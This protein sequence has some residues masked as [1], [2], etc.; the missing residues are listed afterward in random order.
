MLVDILAIGSRGDVQP[1]VALGKGLQQE[2]YHV[3]LV[4]LDGFGELVGRHG[5]EHISIG[6]SPAQIAATETGQ[7]WIR[8]RQSLSGFLR[9][10]MRVVNE[11]LEDG[12]ARYWREC[13]E[14][15]A[16]ITSIGGLPLAVHVAEKMAIPLIRA[17][18]MPSV[19]TKYDWNGKTSSAIAMRGACEAFFW[20]VFRSLL[21]QGIRRPS[22]RAREHILNLP[23]L[24]V[25]EPIGDMVR[26]QI[27]LLDAYSTAVVPKPPDWGEWIHVTGYWFLEESE[28]WSPPDEL[29][30]FLD[31]GPPP[32]FVGFG[33]TPF[34]QPEATTSMIVQALTQLG[35][36][37]I[38]VAGTSGLETGRLSQ[39]ILSVVSVPHSWLF[40]Q[41]CAA[42]HHGGAGVTG[43]ALRAGLPSV[44]IPIFAD[45][46]FWGR[47]VYELGAGPRPI[48]AKKLTLSSLVNALQVVGQDEIRQ[49]AT[50]IGE[51]IRNE[52]GVSNAVDAINEYIR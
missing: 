44:V 20:T 2:G 51:K 29:T 30:E 34:P 8:Q 17:Q 33:S 41:V 18:T 32:V 27:P 38:L 9:G 4:T 43:A 48:P 35:Q 11:L 50:A 46:P 42:V 14:T 5:L 19:P 12:L 22:N 28:A 36:R 10:G 24:G 21:W 40:P 25:R 37:G 16:L 15:Q 3:R 13:Q 1:F 23:A 39:D 6:R 52:D 7:D 49:R 26:R 47:R 45:Q 31:S